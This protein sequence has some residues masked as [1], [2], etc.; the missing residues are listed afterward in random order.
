MKIKTF[1]QNLKQESYD[2]PDVLEKIKPIAYSKEYHIQERRQSVFKNLIQLVPVMTVFTIC[3]L[4]LFNLDK[5]SY[6]PEETSVNHN[7]LT[8]EATEIFDSYIKGTFSNDDI[9]TFDNNPGI[10]KEC[11][12]DSYCM[13]KIENDEKLII[14]ENIFNFLLDY[15]KK[16]PNAKLIEATNVVKDEFSL[17]DEKIYAVCDAYKYIKNNSIGK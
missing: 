10:Q 5:N 13:W 3:L 6:L 7:A 2:I 4:V 8:P 1:K 11:A 14:D 16:N 15:M 17:P 9:E 12:N